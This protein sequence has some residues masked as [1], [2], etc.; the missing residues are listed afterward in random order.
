MNSFSSFLTSST[1]H[2]I[3]I[4]LQETSWLDIIKLF[5][6]ESRMNHTKMGHLVICFSLLCRGLGLQ[7]DDTIHLF[8]FMHCR[9]AISSAIRL[10]VIGP[11]RGQEL[12]LEFQSQVEKLVE[13]SMEMM[14]KASSHE[15]MVNL[16]E[17]Y[18]LGWGTNPLLDILQGGHDRLYSRLF[19]S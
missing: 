1:L 6:D 3:D 9:T 16:D 18:M 19:N 10:G 11:Y 2:E 8:L 17:I 13:S 4:E 5:K 15:E 14:S 12:L 7:I